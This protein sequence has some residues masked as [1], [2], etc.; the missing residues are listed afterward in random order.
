MAGGAGGWFANLDTGVKIIGGVL[1]AGV[2]LFALLTAY[3][4]YNAC[5]FAGIAFDSTTGAPV[6]GLFLGYDPNYSGR[7][8]EGYT[9]HVEKVLANSGNDGAFRGD[10]RGAHDGAAD[11]SFELL[12][13]GQPSGLPGFPCLGAMHTA[14]RVSSRGDTSGINVRVVGC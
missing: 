2:T 14:I 9:P 6:P 1:T 10:C 11:D 7:F 8:V 4:A 5:S 12:Y 13:F 3:N